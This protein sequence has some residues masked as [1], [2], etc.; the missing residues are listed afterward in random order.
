MKTDFSISDANPAIYHQATHDTEQ[1]LG[2]HPAIRIEERIGHGIPELMSLEKPWRVLVA[3]VGL[4]RFIHSFEWQLAY[5]QEL[6]AQPEAVYYVSFF[7]N[8]QAIA[9]FPLQRVRRSVGRVPLWLWEHP[10]HPHLVLGEPL[11]DKKWANPDLFLRLIRILN[12]HS[13]LPWDALHFPNLLDDSVAMR[14][15]RAHP[16]PL[17]HQEQIDEN[18]FFPCSDM[19]AALAHCSGQFKRNLGRQGRKLAQ[20]GSVTLTL[21]RQ[22]PELEAAFAD[23]L[24]LE[25]SGWKG[26]E[27]KA[28]AINLH[29]HLLGFY[30]ALKDR[31]SP[32]RNCLIS[33][34]Q[35]NGVTI[36]AQFCLQSAGTL[37]ILKMAY[38]EAWHA[39]APGGQLLY[40]LL[41]YCCS[42]PEIHQLNLV[43][44]PAWARGRWNPE[45]QPVW[46]TYMF[47]PRLRG[48]W[49][50]AM[51][52]CK[53]RFG[54]GSP[55]HSAEKIRN[56]SG[57]QPSPEM[58]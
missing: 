45:S 21:A 14:T 37:Y 12:Q 4:T 33:L 8:G 52:R 54:K 9:I 46:E 6:E 2:Y 23:F 10:T 40:K 11:I 36:A 49:G 51:R 34:L 47:R 29:P 48:L 50:L 35:L 18:M 28:S 5:L 39:E 15:L 41:E 7:I 25:A 38:D 27:G 56:D 58:V 57:K 19:P 13:R 42:E 43:T 24:R 17:M 26:G 3:T 44:G 1:E 53:Q 55:D 30:R 32:T 20:R 31:F 16:L 22:G